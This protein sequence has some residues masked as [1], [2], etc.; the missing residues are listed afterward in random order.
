MK[1]PN[2]DDPVIAAPYRCQMGLAPVTADHQ[3]GGDPSLFAAGSGRLAPLTENAG[4]AKGG[5][6]RYYASSGDPTGVGFANLPRPLRRRVSDTSAPGD[7]VALERALSI[8]TT[9]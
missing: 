2:S 5:P 4:Q 8:G 1:R 6:G 7:C 9:V 3:N